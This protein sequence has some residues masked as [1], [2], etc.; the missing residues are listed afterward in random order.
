MQFDNCTQMLSQGRRMWGIHPD[1]WK[2][3]NQR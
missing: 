2:S 1:G 3:E